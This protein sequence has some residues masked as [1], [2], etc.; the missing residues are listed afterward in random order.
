MARPNQGLIEAYFVP[1]GGS[2]AGGNPDAYETP[3]IE[4]NPLLA[5]ASIIP[6][7]VGHIMR[8]NPYWPV[9]TGDSLRGFYV[10][11]APNRRPSIVLWAVRN[12]WFYAA[13]VENTFYSASAGRRVANQIGEGPA[14][15]WLDEN[16]GGVSRLL[17]DTTRTLWS[18]GVFW[19]GRGG[20]LRSGNRSALR[21]R[22]VSQANRQVRSFRAQRS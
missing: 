14:Q 17:F 10:V 19:R 18:H 6:N 8:R 13:F 7:Y 2:V 20:L 15:R 11:Q 12:S 4:T 5:A 22:I 21:Q 16:L 3:Q 1:R 9:D